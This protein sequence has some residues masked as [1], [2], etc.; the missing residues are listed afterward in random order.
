MFAYNNK[1]IIPDAESLVTVFLFGL[2]ITKSKFMSDK[3]SKRLSTF[4][5]P[6]QLN[7]RTRNVGNLKQT[8]MCKT[9]NLP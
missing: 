3:G 2:K 6:V 7:K 8:V 5:I 1:N 4:L 9:S